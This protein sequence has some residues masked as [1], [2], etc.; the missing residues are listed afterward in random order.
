MLLAPVNDQRASLTTD[1]TDRKLYCSNV[2][3]KTNLSYAV[4]C[5]APYPLQSP[6]GGTNGNL[7][8]GRTL[9]SVLAFTEGNSW[10]T[11][12]IA[13]LLV[14]DTLAGH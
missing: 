9:D 4:G 5:R 8:R 7:P 1:D 13:T 14:K 2:P 12:G 10:G 11:L 3:A 6:P